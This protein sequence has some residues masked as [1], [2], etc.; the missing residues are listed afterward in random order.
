[1][2]GGSSQGHLYAGKPLETAVENCIFEG[3]KGGKWEGEVFF[4]P[5]SHKKGKKTLC[6]FSG[7][8]SGEPREKNTKQYERGEVD[9]KNRK[10]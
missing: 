1:M 3:E 2:V 10:G 8:N 7:A 6:S 9:R 5:F 4:P